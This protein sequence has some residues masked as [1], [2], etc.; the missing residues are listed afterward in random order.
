[1]DQATTLTAWASIPREI[2]R[3][4]A[5]LSARDLKAR[6]GSE[7]WSIREYVHHLVEANLVAS[8]IVVAALGRPGCKF[9]WSWMIPDKRWMS[10]LGYDRAPLEPAIELLEALCAHVAGLA[11]GTP[12]SKRPYVR[13]LGSTG[14][15]PRR[16][17]LKQVLHEECDHARH[18]LRDIAATRRAHSRLRRKD[19]PR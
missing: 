9:D 6:G 11:R 10:R 4:I 18:H 19:R 14:A 7:G 8:T 13:L 1:V 5:G 3:A 15:R 2:R 12:E 17:T 16:R